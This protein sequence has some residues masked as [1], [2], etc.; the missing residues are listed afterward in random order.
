MSKVEH[1]AICTTKQPQ[2]HLG[3]TKGNIL[4]EEVIV[5]LTDD[6][7]NLWITTVRFCILV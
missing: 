3:Q 1:C 4:N 5:S 7:I 6:L 2:I